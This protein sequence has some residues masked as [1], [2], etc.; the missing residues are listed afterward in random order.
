MSALT[1]RELLLTGTVGLGVAALAS[2]APAAVATAAERA[3]HYDHICGTSL[4]VWFTADR[5][6]DAEERV[7]AEVARL[8][9]LF[10][11]YDDSELFRFNRSSGTVAVSPDLMAVQCG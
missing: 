10:S 2:P 6:T 9:A 7:L 4:D 5:D 8:T 1:R 3:F 11:L